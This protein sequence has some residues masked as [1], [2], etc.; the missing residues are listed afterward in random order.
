LRLRS[1][2][3]EGCLR[4]APGQRAGQPGRHLQLSA[5]LAGRGTVGHHRCCDRTPVRVHGG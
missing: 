2:T 4:L 1:S 3:L 5:N